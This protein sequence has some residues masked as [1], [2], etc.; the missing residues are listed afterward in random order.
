MRYKSG[1]GVGPEMLSPGGFWLEHIRFRPK[2]RRP[3]D[4]SGKVPF[5]QAVASLAWL[6]PRPPLQPRQPLPEVRTLVAHCV[7]ADT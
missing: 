5:I 1:A 4:S 6:L 2:P 7:E 3:R